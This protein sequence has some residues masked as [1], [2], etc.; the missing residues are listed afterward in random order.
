MGSLLDVHCT[1]C[2]LAAENVPIGNGLSPL[3]RF[4]EVRLFYCKRCEA[5]RP[6]KVLQYA[7]ALKA[8]LGEMDL[9]PWS[10]SSMTPGQAEMFE[11]KPSELA[12]LLLDARRR[13]QCECKAS[14]RGSIKLPA[15]TDG[16][17]ATKCPRCGEKCL[18]MKNVGCFD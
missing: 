12:K 10:V 8:A 1:S 14:L 4:F 15:R 11:L 16:A 6:A 5:L 2:N 9:R 13:P 7:R 18:V 17:D 3:W